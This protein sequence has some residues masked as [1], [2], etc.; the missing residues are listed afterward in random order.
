MRS[1]FTVAGFQLAPR[2]GTIASGDAPRKGQGRGSQSGSLPAMVTFSN[3]KRTSVSVHLACFRNIS[4]L[5]ARAGYMVLTSQ[6]RPRSLISSRRMLWGS[7]RRERDKGKA[8][9]E[10]RKESGVPM[11]LLTPY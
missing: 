4:R 3:P 5:F 6:G 9:K 7:E 10:G 11:P 1:P 2:S 8:I